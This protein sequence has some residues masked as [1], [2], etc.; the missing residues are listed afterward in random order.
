MLNGH[1]ETRARKEVNDCARPDARC[2]VRARE[3]ENDFE[4][5]AYPRR[6]RILGVKKERGLF[7]A[8]A[9]STPGI[10]MIADGGLSG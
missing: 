4:K 10:E 5:L 7:F 9:G 8:A 1:F 6:R 3:H 2:K